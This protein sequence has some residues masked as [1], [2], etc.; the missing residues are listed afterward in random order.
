MVVLKVCK[1]RALEANIT[2]KTNLCHL[3]DDVSC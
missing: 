1:T 2:V 3:V